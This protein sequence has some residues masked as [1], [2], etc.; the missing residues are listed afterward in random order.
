[1]IVEEFIAKPVEDRSDSGRFTW[2]SPSNIALIKYWGKKPDQIPANPSISF[3]LETCN[4][5]TT[6]EFS[7]KV[8]AGND[9]SFEV[10]FDG[11]SNEDFRPKIKTFFDR[12]QSYVSFLS[13]YHFKIDTVN[14]FPHSSGIASSASGMSALALCIMSLEKHLNPEIDE[15]YFYRKASFHENVNL[16][17]QIREFDV[18]TNKRS[19]QV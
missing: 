12:I 13:L 18:N 8:R 17:P 16:A 19:T 9:F 1:M 15:D 5:Q 14:T 2:K 11:Q 3:T 4:T 6:L 10:I 7:K